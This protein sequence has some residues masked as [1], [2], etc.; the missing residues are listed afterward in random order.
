MPDYGLNET[1]FLRPT[2]DEL[3][4]TQEERAKILFGD[5][6]DISEQGVLGKFI[7]LTCYDLDYAWQALEET[8]YSRFINTARGVGLDRLATF[9]GIK[10]NPATY[11]RHEIKLVGT[12]NYTLPMGFLVSTEDN[13]QFYTAFSVQLDSQGKGTVYADAIEAGTSGNVPVGSITKIVNPSADISSIQHSGIVGYAEDIETDTELRKRFNLTISG[14]GSG[15]VDS[16][17]GAIMR[18][19][20]VDSCIIVENNTAQTDGEGRPPHSFE[21]FVTAPESQNTLIAQAIFDKKPIGIKTF[22]DITVDIVDDGGFKHSIYFSRTDEVKVYI[23]INIK[24]NNYYE[25]TGIQEIKDN[26]VQVINNLGCGDDVILSSLYGHIYS[27]T[28]IEEV[29]L[30]Q[31]STNGTTYSANNITVSD[32][33]IARLLEQNI[34]VTVVTD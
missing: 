27:V 24:T 2:F 32:N 1:G 21:C 9:A 20:N 10:R 33:Q 11:A 6:I 19:P 17:R 23:K 28:G 3:V 31:L 26:L 7:R 34:S 22:G 5:D 8:Y 18:V 29:S 14:A 30:L 15:T 12:G 13:I 25:T 4:A 16:I